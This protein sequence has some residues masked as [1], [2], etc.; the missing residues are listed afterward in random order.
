MSLLAD[1]VQPAAGAKYLVRGTPEACLD[2]ATS[3]LADKGYE[4]EMR[5]ENQVSMFRHSL[6]PGIGCFLFIMSLF[7]FGAALLVMLALYWIKRRA[8]VVALPFEDGLS[9]VTVTWSNAY[10]KKALDAW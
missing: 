2:S 6:T 5:N 4:I 9:R 3:Y 7:T 8:T 10:A 1:E